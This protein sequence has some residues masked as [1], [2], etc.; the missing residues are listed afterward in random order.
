MNYL[1]LYLY[2]RQKKKKKKKKTTTTTTTVAQYAACLAR[3][4]KPGSVTQYLN[5]SRVLHLE[6]GHPHPYKASWYVKTTLKG[7]EKCN[8]CPPERTKPMISEVLLA[9]RRGLHFSNVKDCVFWV[10]C[11][12]LFLG[13]LRKSNLFQ[14]N[15]T[16]DPAKKLTRDNVVVVSDNSINVVISWSKTIQ[17]REN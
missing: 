9:V 6:C 16:F 4:L 14:D 15:W 2:Q 13:L 1:T 10:I 8:G 3:C 7:V 5:I 11:L 12:V 17:R